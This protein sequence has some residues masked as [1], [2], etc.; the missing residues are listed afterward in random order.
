MSFQTQIVHIIG[1]FLE[2]I[3]SRGRIFTQV[4]VKVLQSV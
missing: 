3:E 2:I 1:I 4:P